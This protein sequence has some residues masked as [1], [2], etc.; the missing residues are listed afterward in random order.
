MPHKDKEVRKRYMKKWSRQYN[1]KHK[2]W[3]TPRGREKVKQRR[4]VVHKFLIEHKLMVGCFKCG[5]KEHHAA[6]DFHHMINN[7]DTLLCQAKSMTKALMEIEK[8]VVLCSNCHRVLHW[9]ER[10]DN[11][12]E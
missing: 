5:Y 1:Q 6:L 9:K 7:K 11:T 10:H 4:L 12:R 8:C 3:K 2:L